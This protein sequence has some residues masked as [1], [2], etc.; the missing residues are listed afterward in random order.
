MALKLSTDLKNYI[1]SNGIVDAMAGTCG[2]AGTASLKVYSGAQP[3]NADAAATGT[4]LV[5]IASL[6]WTD[7]TGCIAGTASLAGTVSYTGTAGTTGTAGWARLETVSVGYNG[8]AATFRIDGGVG[9]A[10]TQTFVINSVAIATGGIVTL[11]TAPIS[12]S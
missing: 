4:L 10:S 1:I 3:A 12:L 9:T 8:T 2:T 6:G 5:T 11:L 7:A